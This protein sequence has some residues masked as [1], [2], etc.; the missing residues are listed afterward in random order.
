MD[1]ITV[2]GLAALVYWLTDALKEASAGAWKSL[3][4][5]LIAAAAGIAGV[6]IY[7]ETGWAHGLDLSGITLDTADA[8]EKVLIGLSIAASAGVGS[9]TLR[10]INPADPTVRSRFG[11]R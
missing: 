11:E 2:I 9:D 1:V 6:F 7:A 5:R 4:G 10:A 8:W 3:V